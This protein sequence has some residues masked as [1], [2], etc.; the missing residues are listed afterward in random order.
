MLVNSIYPQTTN[1]NG[2]WQK[3]RLNALNINEAQEII[4]NVRYIAQKIPQS[5]RI[6][7]I[8]TNPLNKGL[9]IKQLENLSCL[10]MMFHKDFLLQISGRK[11]PKM[12]LKSIKRCL[13]AKTGE[14]AQQIA[15]SAAAKYDFMKFRRALNR[16][17]MKTIMEGFKRYF[18][19]GEK[20]DP[21]DLFAGMERLR[22]ASSLQTAKRIALGVTGK[23]IEL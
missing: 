3:V 6:K 4:S 18:K 10:G 2:S 13:G 12:I 19:P 7:P 15:N 20:F 5:V 16:A 8:D 22:K 23:P 11:Y 9:D 21:T 17:D 14:K 1:F